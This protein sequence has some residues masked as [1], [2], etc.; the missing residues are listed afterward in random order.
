MAKK[1][2]ESDGGGGSPEW[3]STFSD[4]MNLLMCFFVLL[5]SMSSPDQQKFQELAA[6]M[7]ASFSFFNA[8]STAIGEGVLI[9]SG[10]S[11]LNELAAYY[12]NMGMNA[13]GD[14]T[15][16]EIKEA[17][18][19]VM[20]AAMEESEQMAENIEK[21]LKAM[22]IDDQ[23]EVEATSKYV[24]LNLN[25]GILFASGEAALKSDAM[26]LIDKVS[27]IL[28]EYDHNTIAIEGHTDNVPISTSRYPDNTML[29]QYRAYSVFSY[30]VN[31]KGFDESNMLCIG[32]GEA[33]PIAS[34]A[35]AEGRAQNRRVEIKIYNSYSGE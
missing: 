18:Q 12:N 21:E 7:Q 28:K 27:D 1:K 20:D 9:S 22:M 15:T 29:S 19:E 6:A 25:S 16:D 32:R 10:A 26:T 24:M 11:Q 17:M 14:V 23:V 8:G 3:M 34:N 31:S 4:L 33:V 5:F 30:F 35:T 2:K 13:E